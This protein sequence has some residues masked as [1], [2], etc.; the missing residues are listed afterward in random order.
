MSLGTTLDKCMMCDFGI[1]LH[2]Q[3]SNRSVLK[4]F[5][6]TRPCSTRCQRVTDGGISGASSS[7]VGPVITLE[8]TD[9][10]LEVTTSVK[11]V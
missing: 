5:C 9:D 2:L 7:L 3:L 4:I 10:T 8:L 1:Y 6:F 11:L